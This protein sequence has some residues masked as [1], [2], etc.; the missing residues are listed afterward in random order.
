MFMKLPC[1]A[2]VEF[3]PTT[4]V[5]T[6]EHFDEE[7]LLYI[8]LKNVYFNKK[9]NKICRVSP[10]A[11]TMDDFKAKVAKEEIPGPGLPPPGYL[12]GRPPPNFGL[13][14]AN[15][16]PRTAPPGLGRPRWY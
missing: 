15:Y 8:G 7:D 1:L 2:N 3:Y 10:A 12:A 16:R 9:L 4:Q 6:S 11:P 13:I 14:S 5:D